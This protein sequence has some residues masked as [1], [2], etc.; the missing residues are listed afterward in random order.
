[1]LARI[2]E[3]MGLATVGISLIREH[4][5]RVR[6]PR[7]LFVPFPY[8][9]ALGKP[10][11]PAFQQ[12]VIEAALDLL[13]RKE[14]AKPVLEDFPVILDE[15]VVIDEP[16]ECVLVLPPPKTGL[17][18]SA[19]QWR[20]EVF[21]EIAALRPFYEES[22]EKLGRT[23]LGA[24]HI[25]PEEI[26]RAAAYIAG[27]V[28]EEEVDPVERPAETRLVQYLRWCADDLKVFY[29]E[30]AVSKQGERPWN[31]RQL[32]DWLWKQTVLG[33]LILAMRAKIYAGDDQVD[34]GIAFGLVPRGYNL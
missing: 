19:Q 31:N 25:A 20:E 30:A 13:K 23:M 27:F 2:L 22:R 24:S 21:A 14:S 15:E 11:D 5:E 17:D 12:Q 9:R 26:E 8:G 34:K 33:S 32:Q 28:S 7:Y 29:L 18:R 16:L 1:M 10:N 4:T 3:N 6:P